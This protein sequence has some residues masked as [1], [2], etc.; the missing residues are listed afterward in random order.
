MVEV[1][2]SSPGDA[3][4]A[5]TNG[6]TVEDRQGSESLRLE[7]ES[8]PAYEDAVVL[9]ASYDMSVKQLRDEVFTDNS[10]GG[11]YYTFLS[12]MRY[13]DIRLGAFTR[14]QTS[15]GDLMQRVV[16]PTLNPTTCFPKT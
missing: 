13:F 2:L 7:L 4:N 12:K 15:D 1:D 6:N 14:E 8:R 5:Q 16:S 11:V 10:Q 9:N 3:A